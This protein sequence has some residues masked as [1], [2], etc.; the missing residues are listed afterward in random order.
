MSAK[1]WHQDVRV[2]HLQ[3][4]TRTFVFEKVKIWTSTWHCL[5]F[6]S[7]RWLIWDLQIMSSVMK[8]VFFSSDYWISK[9]HLHQFVKYVVKICASYGTDT[10]FYM[11]IYMTCILFWNDKQNTCISS[12][13]PNNLEY[14]LTIWRSRAD[15]L[16]FEVEESFKFGRWW[17]CFKKY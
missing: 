12:V 13:I 8:R 16:S 4:S 6:I 17:P 5:L 11:Y 14:V 3:K 9:K 7:F 15:L 1:F 10:I 2:S